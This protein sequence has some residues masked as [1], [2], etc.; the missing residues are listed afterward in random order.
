LRGNSVSVG[1]AWRPDEAIRRT[2]IKSLVRLSNAIIARV[3][4]HGDASLRICARRDVTARTS[5]VQLVA[6]CASLS[7][8][9]LRVM[10][11]RRMRP[12]HDVTPARPLLSVLLRKIGKILRQRAGLCGARRRNHA[13]PR[14]MPGTSVNIG[15]LLCTRSGTRGRSRCSI[16]LFISCLEISARNIRPRPRWE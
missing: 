9:P 5:S 12:R 15:R 7:V 13:Q 16:L 3:R 10:S 8:R 6:S 11:V 14:R 4:L 1:R 2:P